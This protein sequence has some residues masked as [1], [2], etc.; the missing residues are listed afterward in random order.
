MLRI[1]PPFVERAPDLVPP[2]PIGGFFVLG[3]VLATLLHVVLS[4]LDRRGVLRYPVARMGRGFGNALVTM[5]SLLQPD[6][7][8]PEDRPGHIQI[9]RDDHDGDAPDPEHAPVLFQDGSLPDDGLRIRVDSSDGRPPDGPA[10]PPAAQASDS[11]P[12]GPGS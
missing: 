9:R 4:R 1:A 10:G 8:P 5:G 3:L 7:P 2:V 6:R 12:T 11:A